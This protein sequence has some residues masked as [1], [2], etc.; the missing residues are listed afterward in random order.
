MGL[1]VASVAVAM[2]AVSDLAGLVVGD[3]VG[4]AGAKVAGVFFVFVL[5]V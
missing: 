1:G 2:A 3:G 5:N 4:G